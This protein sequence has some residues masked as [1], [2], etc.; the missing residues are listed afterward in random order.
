VQNSIAI[1]GIHTGIGKT[2]ASAVIAEA[3]GADYWKPVQAG[4]KERDAVLVRDLLTDG[5]NRVH[6]ESVLLTQP[7]SPHAAAAA[8]N[9][10]IDYKQFEWPQTQNK[11]IVETAGGL[12][13]P[14][15]NDCTM[16]DFISYYQ[17]PTLL[18]SLNYLGSI[19]HTL[20]TI[21]VM[22]SRGIQLLGIIM[23]GLENESSESFIAEYSRVP[24]LARIPFISEL[25]NE[26]VKRTAFQLKPQLATILK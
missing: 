26:S 12:L 14:M 25:N 8:D 3:L 11:L 16:A 7:L 17:L 24:I 13:S 20:M 21:E 19:N 10:V 22:K 6:E 18:V 5:G 4:V 15:Y 23:N 1:A 2:I 9:I